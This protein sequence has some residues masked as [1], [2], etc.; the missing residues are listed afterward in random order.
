MEN[1]WRHLP[2]ANSS[3]LVKTIR[4]LPLVALATGVG[5]RLPA[6]QYLQYLVL[7]LAGLAGVIGLLVI[8]RTSLLPLSFLIVTAVLLPFNVLDRGGARISSPFV[9]VALLLAVFAL[10][11]LGEQRAS[12]PLPRRVATPLLMF[13]GVATLSLVAGQFP[14]FSIRGA[15]LPA[16]L[17][18]LSIF[19]LSAAAFVIFATRL[20]TREQIAKITWVFLVAGAVTTLLQL[21]PRID[22]ALAFIRGS[23]G[24]TQPSS[25]GSM[26]W[27]WLVA[28]AAGQA[29]MNR[30]LR[31]AARWCLILVIV[32]VLFHALV[33]RTGWTSGWLPPLVCLGIV[34]FQRFPRLTIS[35]S[36]LALPVLL[37]ST[38]LFDSFWHSE[39]YSF[40]TRVAAWHVLMDVLGRSP[41]IGLGPANYYYY[42]SLFPILGWHVNF[43][44]HNN[45]IDI[46]GQTGLVGFCLFMWFILEMGFLAI[47]TWRKAAPGFD[48]G[49]V[50]GV[51]AGM[52]GSFAA[53]ML[54]DWLLP[55]V[56][57]VGLLGFR[58]SV[59]FWIFTGSLVA[60]SR[61]MKGTIPEGARGGE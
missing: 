37:L 45:Y 17:A 50:S 5:A 1:S 28:I 44:S 61:V 21:F 10:E 36:L 51:Q 33:L 57:N 49:F 14:W 55:F 58:S 52:A 15:P 30:R 12:I 32:L 20:N 46:I 8:N 60:L 22:K 6:P 34:L 43:S 41:L 11:T 23:N 38:S 24:L 19:L 27:T 47:R 42:T 2:A 13:L 35:L 39:G 48:L 26:F 7:L 4:V 53:G 25:I 54:G 40:S 56:Y 9:M 3:R 29:F 31:R 59:I 16:Q 18:G